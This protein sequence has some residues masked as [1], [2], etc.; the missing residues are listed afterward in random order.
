MQ[1]DSLAHEMELQKTYLDILKDIISGNIKPDSVLPLDSAKLNQTATQYLEKSQSEKDFIEKFE[2]EEKY[3]LTAIEGK[4]SEE[5]F[6]FFRPTKGIISSSF[7]PSEQQYGIT[8]ITSPNETVLSVLEGTVVYVAYTFDYGW[9]IQVQ[10]ESNYLSNYRNNTSLL[11]KVGDRVKAGEAI[12]ITGDNSGVKS[13]TLFYFELWK[14]GRP[15]NPEDV[16][17]F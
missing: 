11:K 16:I 4:A 10:H 9:V 14:Q 13:G 8:I 3:N 17:L 12:A 7:N 2:R 6:V 5:I 15:L 1:V